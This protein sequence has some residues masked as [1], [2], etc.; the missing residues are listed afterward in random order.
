MSMFQGVARV[1]AYLSKHHTCVNNFNHET[2]KIKE[3]NRLVKELTDQNVGGVLEALGHTAPVLAAGLENVAK[4][5][6]LLGCAGDH[7]GLGTDLLV[8]FG[9]K[10]KRVMQELDELSKNISLMEQEIDKPSLI[11]RNTS[12]W[13]FWL[14]H[15][16]VLSTVLHFEQS[17]VHDHHPLPGSD[18]DREELLEMYC[19]RLEHM[20]KEYSPTQLII[21]LRHM[22]GIIMGEAVFDEPLFKQLAEA[23]YTLESEELD[24]FLGP[25]F[26]F[27]QSVIALQ[28]RAMRMLL[29]FIMYEQEDALYER[30]LVAIASN[31]VLQL[32]D[33]S[34]PVS[35]FHWYIKF[36]AHGLNNATL[37]SVKWPEWYAYDSI[38]NL[39]GWKGHPG[40]HGRF[41]IEPQRDELQGTFKITTRWRDGYYVYMDKTA[42]KNVRVSRRDPGNQGYWK[43]NIKDVRAR[44]FTLTTVEHPNCHMHMELLGNISGKNGNLDDS[45]YFKLCDDEPDGPPGDGNEIELADR[46]QERP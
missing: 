7:L 1:Q 44:T 36:K 35:Q 32:G 38:G 18:V 45:C 31:V 10:E 25:F 41:K 22:H 2:K 30:D 16:K 37:L 20:V 9:F 39:R 21:D 43:F 46:A 29:S 6:D 13:R 14:I 26:F 11:T 4:I 42:F 24:K 3:A 40:D 34:N 17:A 5:A 15:D 8:A 33:R 27:F 28:V 19:K 12:L 23:A